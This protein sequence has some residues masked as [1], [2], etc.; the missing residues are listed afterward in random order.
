MI[1]QEGFDGLPQAVIP[2]E[3]A[4]VG[5]AIDLRFRD[6][7]QGQVAATA[8]ARVAHEERAELLSLLSTPNSGRQR[9]CSLN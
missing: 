6:L 9:C 2:V 3:V 8:L 4:L 5:E 7:Y 1:G